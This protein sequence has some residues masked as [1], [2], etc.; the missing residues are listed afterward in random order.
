M[1]TD[2]GRK[3]ELTTDKNIIKCVTQ[4]W[5]KFS[6]ETQSLIWSEVQKRGL[7]D[8]VLYLRGQK[9]RESITPEGILPG[10][11]CEKCKGTRLNPHTGRCARCNMPPGDFGYCKECDKFWSIPPGQACPEHSGK[12]HAFKAVTTYRRLANLI[13]DH[14]FIIILSLISGLALA[15]F[16]IVNRNSFENISDITFWSIGAS[17]YFIYYFF[18][19]AILQR[20][21]AKLI[22]GTKVIS[23][24]GAKPTPGA[25][26]KRTLI[27]YFV[28]FEKFSFLGAK[29]YGWHDKWSVTYVIRAKRFERKR[30]MDFISSID[31]EPLQENTSQMA[32]ASYVLSTLPISLF[33]SLTSIWFFSPL[34]SHEL[35]YFDTSSAQFAPLLVFGT[36]VVYICGIAFGLKALIGIKKSNGILVGRRLA[37]AGIMISSVFLVSFFVL[38]TYILYTQFIPGSQARVT[39]TKANLKS[40]NKAVWWYFKDTGYL[41][42]EEE[43]LEV[44]LKKP[45]D[46][47]EN[48]LGTE[49]SL[50]T[51]QLTKEDKKEIRLKYRIAEYGYLES[52]RLPKDGWG[53]D[54]IYLRYPKD[55][56]SFVIMSLGADGKEGGKGYDADLLSTDIVREDFAEK[57]RKE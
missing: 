23:P 29:V 18:F 15:R 22:T 40:L 50:D 3:W 4:K 47:I 32:I 9:P 7:S 10:F 19:E 24:N 36:I 42:T 1:K 14:T 33:L 6:S 51:E 16:G 17:L 30:D 38:T 53:R 25:V 21:P 11:V 54:F 35:Q 56:V 26:A 44:L 45:T 39:A 57:D 52:D 48:V 28:L 37:S 31:F 8:Y 43:G 13:L 55:G 2:S 46:K 27:R 34:M 49:K 41:P 20:T 5:Q 12:L